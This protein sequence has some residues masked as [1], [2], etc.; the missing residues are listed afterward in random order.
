MENSN[1]IVNETGWYPG[2]FLSGLFGNSG[3]QP[4]T[5]ITYVVVG[6]VILI[7][8]YGAMLMATK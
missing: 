2:E 8:A 4:G 7:I 6:G 5:I 1:D 3:W